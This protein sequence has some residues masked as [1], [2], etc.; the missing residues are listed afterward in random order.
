[1]SS[2]TNS[3]NAVI[4]SAEQLYGLA[5][6]LNITELEK[7]IPEYTKIVQKHFV[8]LEESKLTHKDVE[9]VKKFLSTNRM[10]TDLLNKKKRNLFKEIKQIQVGKQMQM[11]YPATN[12][13][14]I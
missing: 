9:N 14:I 12:Y 1:M 6:D 7:K 3:F 10:I 4:R 13:P 8:E 11:T 2:N 5:K